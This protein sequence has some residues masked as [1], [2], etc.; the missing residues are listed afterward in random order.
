MEYHNVLPLDKDSAQKIF[1]SNDV[2]RICD[3]M[4]VI[5]FHEPDWKWVQDICL[6][7]FMSD[8]PAVSGLAATCLGHVARIHGQLEKEK[9]LPLLYSRLSDPQIAGRIEDA[10]DDIEMFT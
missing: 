10:L 4:V 6:T 2:D 8:D 9:V 1:A 7:F 3:A 5:A